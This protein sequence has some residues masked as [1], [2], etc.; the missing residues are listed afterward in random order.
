M[1]KEKILKEILINKELREK[2]WPKVQIDKLNINTLSR[3]N[4]KYLTALCYLF[5]ESNQV[6][7]TG[8]ISNIKKTFEL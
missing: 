1:N 4:N 2:Y 3:E 8:M 6:K 5:E 7:F